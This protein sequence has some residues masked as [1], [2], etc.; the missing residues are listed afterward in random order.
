MDRRR[1]ETAGDESTM[2]K[3]S[4]INQKMYWVWKA[5]RG[6]CNNPR[7]P[8]YKWYGGRGITVC[9][10]WSSFR[11]FYADMHET[12]QH[13]LDLDRK[14]NSLGYCKDNCQWVTHSVNTRNTRR[15]IRIE[16]CGENLTLMEWS[17]R[18]GFRYGTV[19][20]R[21]FQF[22]WTFQRSIE[23][24]KRYSTNPVCLTVSE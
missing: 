12:Y 8:D 14:N 4:D 5:M 11:T 1:Q 13:G 24:P 15:N 3:F 23:T 7:N 19:Y 17:E 16:W 20:Q 21:M 10:G 18:L 6:R 9:E 22:G 2:S